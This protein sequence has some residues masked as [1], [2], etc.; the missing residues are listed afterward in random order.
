MLQGQA[1]NC[2]SYR[3]F[4]IHGFKGSRFQGG[5]LDLDVVSELQAYNAILL[6]TAKIL[7]RRKNPQR[8]RL[9]RRFEEQFKLRLS[10]IK[11]GSVLAV[12]ERSIPEQ[13]TLFSTKDELDEAAE[14]V[15]E[16]INCAATD[17]KLPDA[18][19][20]DL[21]YLFEN[22]GK[23]LQEGE[24]FELTKS[25]QDGSTCNA[26]YNLKTREDLLQRTAGAY[27]DVVNLE[28][29][30]TMARVNKPKMSLLLDNGRE[31]EAVF[32]ENDESM[33]LE[34]LM[35]H[36]CNKVR[37]QGR[38]SYSSDG[39]L[40]RL[41]SLDKIEVLPLGSAI[42]ATDVKPIWEQI[43]EMTS[44]LPENAFDSVP[45]DGASNH[46]KYLYGSAK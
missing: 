38:G 13:K 15:T 8:S 12:L 10:A 39:E 6:E 25:A 46:D 40:Q 20:R 21:L 1:R 32:Q 33:V 23:T 17:R 5:G 19:P 41:I 26:K 27:E 9:Q 2:M 31:I 43:E 34:A 24:Y 30:V 18:F 14:L 3:N 29:V 16:V 7:W 11:S 36:D 4:V 42:Y 28:G 35:K 37:I 44:A 22:Y 45:V